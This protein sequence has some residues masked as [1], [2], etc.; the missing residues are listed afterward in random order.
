MLQEDRQLKMIKKN[1]TRKI[2]TELQNM[3]KNDRETYVTFY[4]VFGRQLKYGVY[5]DFGQHKDVLQ[6]L[7]MF[8]SS[9]EQ[10]LVSLAEYVERMPEDQKHIYY[11][12][13]ESN[14][15]IAKLPQTEMV[16]DKGY[17]ILYFTEDVD[18]FAIRMLMNY[19]EKE[20]KNVSSGDLGLESEDRKSVV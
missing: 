7:L 20:F 11:A 5:S 18:E 2:K 17:E 14:E 13:G 6:D 1:I 16:T 10:K 8:Y 12:T 19:K 9:K 15:R 3:L 4:E